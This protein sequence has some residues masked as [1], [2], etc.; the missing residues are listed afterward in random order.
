MKKEGEKTFTYQKDDA[1][2][3][4]EEEEGFHLLKLAHEGNV[5]AIR[6]MG[7]E[8]VTEDMMSLL[9]ARTLGAELTSGLR[10][11]ESPLILYMRDYIQ[12]AQSD[13]TKNWY[14]PLLQF[15]RECGFS[16]E[17]VRA[18][19]NAQFSWDKIARQNM[20]AAARAI[21]APPIF[22]GY[23]PHKALPDKT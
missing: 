9:S 5:E 4:S 17:E 22:A 3:N 16:D 13:V 18:V 2:L 21:G 20:D 14:K 1:L 8:E 15:L 19:L 12:Q 10:R 11:N 23:S 6:K 7:V